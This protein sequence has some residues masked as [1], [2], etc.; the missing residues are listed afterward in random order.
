MAIPLKKPPASDEGVGFVWFG[1]FR[2]LHKA[3]DDFYARFEALYA[4]FQA[5]YTYVYT[6][7]TTSGGN[8]K[9]RLLT[10]ADASP[11]TWPAGVDA[12]W[13]T[14]IAGG[15]G[16]STRNSTTS[17]GGG[18]AGEYCVRYFYP[19]KAVTTTAF[20]IGLGGAAN[21]S[22]TAT[23]FGNLTLNPGLTGDRSATTTCWGGKGGGNV[24]VAPN[25]RVVG[26]RS[27]DEGVCTFSGANGGG[28][29]TTGAAGNAG[30]GSEMW[31][32]G[33]GGIAGTYSGGGGGAS[34]PWGIGGSGAS[35]AIAST[36]PAATAYGCGGGGGSASPSATY[37]VGAGGQDGCILL[38]W[39]GA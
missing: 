29:N 22:G 17:G 21:N 10:A 6:L 12:V 14:A 36:M 11:W 2:K 38:E 30:G 19:R 27:V 9:S 34:S 18:G 32:G 28:G 4:S 15:G 33:T 25:T 3:F 23:V 8:L 39:I 24:Q 37:N 26:V 20:T 7:P 1:W 16:G 35:D 5:L 31:A 13:V